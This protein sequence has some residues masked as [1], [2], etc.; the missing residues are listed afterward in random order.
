MAQFA[1]RPPG[2]PQPQFQSQPQVRPED[3]PA[4]ADSLTAPAATPEPPALSAARTALKE[5]FGHDDFRPSQRELVEWVLSGRDVLGVMPTG[6]GKSLVYQVPACVLPGLTIV[7]SPLIS[8]MKDQVAALTEAGIPATCLNSALTAAEQSEAFAFAASGA[9]KLLYVAPERLDTPRLQELV[10]RVPVSLVA[11]DEAHCVSQWGQDFRPSYLGIAEFIACLPERP[12]VAALTATATGDVRANI[13]EALRLRDP[14]VLVSGFDRPNLYFGVERPEPRDKQRCLLRLV[15]KRAARRDA[16]G[17]VSSG[18]TGIVY[19]STRAAVEEV[20]D[21]LWND[22]FASTRYHAGLSAEERRENQDDFLYD[23]ATVMVATNA[24]G[25][26]IDKSNVSFVIHYNMPSDLESYYQEAGRAGRDGS[27]AD[28]ILIYNKKDVQ[29]CRFLIERSRDEGLA[30][31]NAPELAD[32]LYRRDCERLKRMTLYCTTTDCL[33]ST[34]LRYFGETDAPFRCEH[35]SNCSTEVEV[36]DATVDAQ[37]IVS[38]VLRVANTGRQVGKSTIVDVLRGSKAERI[39][40]WRFDE[41]STYGIM[42]DQSAQ[43]VRYVLD[44]L[45]DAG[46][47]GVTDGQYPTVFA[48]SEGRDWLLRTKEP[49]EVKVSKRMAKTADEGAGGGRAF[50]QR[51]ADGTVGSVFGRGSGAGTGAEL[52]ADPELF[53][54][55]RKLR[56]RIASEEGVPAYIVFSNATLADMAAKRPTDEDELLDVSGVGRAKASK[57]GERF[58]ACIKEFGAAGE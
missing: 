12:T 20:C 1:S 9:C 48:T 21:L 38:C 30:N 39:L 17:G 42:A 10:Q 50:G 49:F 7:V 36:E 4:A 32:E 54:E 47:L 19:C 18:Q 46:Y 25:M 6:A 22:G 52:E 34:I 15:R 26:G 23:R 33:R 37:K 28:C 45:V 51:G 13:V 5:Y 44:A 56:T 8:L 2:Q 55:L 57:Y 35:C 11:V 27:P 53:E 3:R 14:Y 31:G 41:L 40:G 24:F 58:L 29:T 16:P 43:H